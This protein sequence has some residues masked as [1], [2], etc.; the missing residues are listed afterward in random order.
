[1][2]TL[3]PNTILP[4]PDEDAQVTAAIA[5]DPDDFELDDEWFS[6]A[7]SASEFFDEDMLSAL[8]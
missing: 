4:T 3:K 1:M 8:K 6:T 5:A 7:L 2:P